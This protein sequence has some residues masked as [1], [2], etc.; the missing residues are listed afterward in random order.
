[1]VWLAW[2]GWLT[3]VLLSVLW[4]WQRWRSRPRP[5]PDDPREGWHC[6]LQTADGRD[7]S[8]RRIKEGSAPT[9]I[10]R[11]HGHLSSHWYRLSEVKGQALIYR[12]ES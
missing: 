9:R 12:P 7:V 4:L 1:M 6:V 8:V 10:E 5:V 3:A 11:G 2:S